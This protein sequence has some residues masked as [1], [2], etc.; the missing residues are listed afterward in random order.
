MKKLTTICL[1]ATLIFISCDKD[2][3]NQ[4]ASSNPNQ[5]DA[6]LTFDMVDN[7]SFEMWVGGKQISTESLDIQDYLK[8]EAITYFDPQ[9]LENGNLQFIGDTMIVNV[10]FIPENSKYEYRFSNDSLY[11]TYPFVGES[12]VATGNKQNL[13]MEQGYFY[14][15]RTLNESWFFRWQFETFRFN[16]ENAVD[17]LYWNKISQMNPM[18]TLVFY[19]QDLSYKN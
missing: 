14:A 7:M 9:I 8:D 13:K 3:D 17:E 16:F 12:F 19:N 4:P 18:D 2:E 6:F 15:S 11:I 10:G 5:G 1:L